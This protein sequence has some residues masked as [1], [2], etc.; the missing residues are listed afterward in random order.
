M[1][2]CRIH[3]FT[4]WAPAGWE[5]RNNAS[6]FFFSFFLKNLRPDSPPNAAT[7]PPTPPPHLL[8]PSSASLIQH[9]FHVL[10]TPKRRFPLPL[11]P[12]SPSPFRYDTFHLF[13]RITLFFSLFFK[14]QIANIPAVIISE[15]ILCWRS[16]EEAGR[17]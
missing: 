8:G 4:P 11:P 2:E 9:T 7:T 6:P 15:S 14:A 16:A 5:R 10:M 12:L 3:T 17:R 1:Q 13:A